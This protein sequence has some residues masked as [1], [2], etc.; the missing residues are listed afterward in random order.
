MRAL[1]CNIVRETKQQLVTVVIGR[2]ATDSMDETDILEIIDGSLEGES[3]GD[4]IHYANQNF[5]IVFKGP[6]RAVR[7]A[8]QLQQVLQ[9]EDIS[10]AFGIH[11]RECHTRSS[12]NS[13]TLDIVNSMLHKIELGEVLISQTVRQFVMGGDFQF[14]SRE[15]L[16]EPISNEIM[17]LYTVT[18]VAATALEEGQVIKEDSLLKTVIGVIE[19]N[20]NCEGFKIEKLCREVGV[21]ERQLQRKLK[22]ITKKSPAQFI[23]SVRLQKAKELLMNKNRNI[24][25]IAFKTGFSNPSYF[26]KCF[27]KE[28]GTS[29]SDFVMPSIAI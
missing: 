21:S 2:V 28:F 24:S 23:I 12:I 4:L 8:V 22:S 9:A 19:S 7:Y 13:Q 1:D 26:A 16:F 10:S 15:R 11:I 27:K 20:L 14:T 17:P 18:H 5:I 25:E 3:Q 29:P 6:S